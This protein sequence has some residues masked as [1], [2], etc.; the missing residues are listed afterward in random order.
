MDTVNLT[1][2]SLLVRIRCDFEETTWQAFWQTSVD[3]RETTDVAE[4]LAMS[5]EPYISPA[6]GFWLGCGKRFRKSRNEV[7]DAQTIARHDRRRR[8]TSESAA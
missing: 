6:A 1:R 2:P 3:D 8:P 4:E 7:P 5:V